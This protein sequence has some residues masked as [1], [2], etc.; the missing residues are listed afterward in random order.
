MSPEVPPLT[1]SPPPERRIISPLSMPAGIFIFISSSF[2]NIPKP[3]QELHFS[4]GTLP[5][6]AQLLQALVISIEPKIDFFISLIFPLPLQ[7]WQLMISVPFLP[8]V[9]LQT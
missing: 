3:S 2:F 8:P 7:V 4:F 1:A 9:P 6:P 5:L